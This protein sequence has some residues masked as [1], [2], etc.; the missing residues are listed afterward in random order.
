MAF[1]VSGKKEASSFSA[2]RGAWPAG[3]RALIPALALAAA[4]ALGAGS[5]ACRGSEKEKPAAPME[6]AAPQQSLTLDEISRLDPKAFGLALPQLREA[7][8]AAGSASVSPATIATIGAELRQTGESTPDY[9]P[10]AVGF[11]QFAS[12][13]LAPSVLPAGQAPRRLS[14][15]LAVGIMRGIRETGKT[16]LFD[17][18][19]LG[20]GEFIR[21]RIVFTARPVHMLNVQFKDCAFDFSPD[22]APNPY[23]QEVIRALLASNLQSVS[24]ASLGGRSG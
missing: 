8:R 4:C 17:G 11:L 6:K 16:I 14:D 9:W 13:H 24:I 20:N 23:L 5:F 19:D 10:T 12:S 2:R 1:T 21:C 7:M 18:G 3:T 15:I 22:A